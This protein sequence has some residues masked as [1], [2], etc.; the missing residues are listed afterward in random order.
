MKV[1]VILKVKLEVILGGSLEVSQRVSQ[2]VSWYDLKI[3]P[4]SESS[5]T[6]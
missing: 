4:D 1:K 6:T 5:R 3:Q 2:R